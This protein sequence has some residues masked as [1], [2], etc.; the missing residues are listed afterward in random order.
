MIVPRRRLLQILRSFPMLLGPA[1]FRFG[2]HPPTRHRTPPNR[3][4]LLR[5][6]RQLINEL[7][8]MRERCAMNFQRILTG[9]WLQAATRIQRGVYFRTCHTVEGWLR[10]LFL[11]PSANAA[12][13]RAKAM[14]LIA[15]D[16]TRVPDHINSGLDLPLNEQLRARMFGEC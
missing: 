2:V 12:A 6:I 14:P 13:L 15:Q 7:A 5:P 9:P 8:A 10:T 1:S 11:D 3:R 16:P 4:V